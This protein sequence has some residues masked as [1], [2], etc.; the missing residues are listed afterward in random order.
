MLY[1]YLLSIHLLKQLWV[2]LNHKQDYVKP[3]A[4]GWIIWQNKEMQYLQLMNNN[5]GKDLAPI[6][7]VNKNKYHMTCL[8]SY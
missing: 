3:E 5:N 1:M 7:I 6:M 2:S 8:S 4:Y